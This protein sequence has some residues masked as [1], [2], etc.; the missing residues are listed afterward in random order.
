MRYK[1][2][3]EVPVETDEKVVEALRAVGT[4]LQTD[5]VQSA[6]ASPDSY[7]L[8]VHVFPDEKE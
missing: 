4:A 5:V 2:L 8:T 1:I 3:L 6:T 7:S